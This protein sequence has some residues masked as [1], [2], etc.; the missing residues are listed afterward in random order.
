MLLSNV[1][2][3]SELVAFDF[4]STV[5]NPFFYKGHISSFTDVDYVAMRWFCVGLREKVLR[6]KQSCVCVLLVLMQ[7]TVWSPSITRSQMQLRRL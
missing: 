7:C 6:K 2:I 1:I 4:D 5:L 3:S